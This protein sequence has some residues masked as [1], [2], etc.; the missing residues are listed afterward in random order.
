MMA[1]SRSACLAMICKKPL[2]VDR[3]ADRAVEQRFHESLDRGDRRLQL[4]RDVG[5]E[6]AADVLQAAKIGDVVQHHHGADAAA[7]GVVQGGAAGLQHAFV[8]AVQHDVVVDR[9][10]AAQRPADEPPQVGV[11][12]DFLQTAA[13]G[14]RL[15]DAQQL[16]RGLVQADHALLVVDGQHSFDHARQDG[17]LFV[18][19]ADDGADPLLQLLR[20]LVEGFGQ[21]GQLVRVGHDQAE[22]ELAAGKAL[23]RLPHLFQRLGPAAPDQKNRTAPPG[24][25]RRSRSRSAGFETARSPDRARPTIR[26]PATTPITLSVALDRHGHR[27]RPLPGRRLNADRAVPLAGQRAAALP[28]RSSQLVA[29]AAPPGAVEA[30]PAPSGESDDE[31]ARRRSSRSRARIGVLAGRGFRR[32]RAQNARPASGPRPSDGRAGCPATAPRTNGLANHSTAATASDTGKT[33]E[34]KSCPNSRRLGIATP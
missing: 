21:A 13:L 28:A 17:P 25:P 18:V 6:I 1:S 24:R 26:R 19:L 7:L 34:G 12:H 8:I 15:I 30:A 11:A 22:A 4:V 10:V 9:L 16:A 3:I 27:Q 14:L 23:G 33:K 29:V 2:G 20:H 31:T 5:H 32:R